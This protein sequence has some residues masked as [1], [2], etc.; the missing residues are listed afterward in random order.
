MVARFLFV[1]PALMLLWPAA[2]QPRGPARQ[3]YR[4]A[5]LGARITGRKIAF[6]LPDG[7]QVKGKVLGVEEAGLRM[8]VNNTSDRQVQPKGEH[9]I[10]AQS[11]SVIRVLEGTKRWRIICTIAA[12]FVG[13]AVFGRAAGGLPDSSESGGGALSAVTMGSLAGGYLLGRALDK[14]ATEIEIIRE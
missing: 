3:Q 9:L 12:P 14:K 7:T 5:D 10:L 8:K 13:V 1:L 11:L 6:V 2:A 4:W